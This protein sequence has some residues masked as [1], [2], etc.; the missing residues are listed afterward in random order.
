MGLR[1]VCALV[2]PVFFP[3]FLALLGDFLLELGKTGKGI[4]EGNRG[5]IV[6][7]FVRGGGVGYL[8]GVL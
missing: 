2:N 8:G 5:S 6:C 1:R 7:V 4:C 3:G